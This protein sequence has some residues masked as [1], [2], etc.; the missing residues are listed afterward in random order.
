MGESHNKSGGVF[1]SWTRSDTNRDGDIGKLIEALKAL[2]VPYWIDDEQIGDF[3][4]I[5]EKVREG[6]SSSK[7]LL[8][9]YSCA[10]PTRKACREEITLALLAA[11]N[12]KEI[13]KR[14]LLLNPEENSN[15]ILEAPLL[16]SRFAN[17]DSLRNI[18]ELAEQIAERVSKLEHSF[19]ELPT[20]NLPRW[21]TGIKWNG[22][23]ERFVG[24]L[25]ELWKIHKY[26]HTDTEIAGTGRAGRSI[27]IVSGPGG[28]GKSLLASEYAHLFSHEYPGGVFW[29]SAFGND[30]SGKQVDKATED[31]AYSQNQIIAIGLNINPSGMDDELLRAQIA[32]RLER[33]GKDVLWIVDDLPSGLSS[34]QLA[35]W[36]CGASVVHEIIT[37]RDSSHSSLPTVQLDVLSLADA[38]SLLLKSHDRISESSARED[39][40]KVASILGCHPL[41]CDVAGLYMFRLN[42]TFTEYAELIENNLSKFDELAQAF[43][44]QLPGGHSREI[45]ATIGTSLKSL[46]KSAWAV[47]RLASQLAQAPIPR[48]LLK[49]TLHLSSSK[50]SFEEGIFGVQRDGLMDW[51]NSGLLVVHVLTAMAAL[52]LD[53]EPKLIP[54]AKNALISVLLSRFQECVSD[55]QRHGE[56]LYL[57]PHARYIT[58]EISDNNAAN[59]LNYVAKLDLERGQLT[60]AIDQ[61]EKLVEWDE[62]ILGPDHPD[63]LTSKNNLAVAYKK[64]GGLPKAIELLKETLADSERILGSDHPNTFSSKNNLAVAYKESGDLPKAIEL[65]KENLADRERILGSDH[66]KTL[67]SKNNLAMTY[68]ES[69][70]LQKAIE[71]LKET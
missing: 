10:Y 62:R 59:L 39:A 51:D 53:P 20:F 42:T 11:D 35:P 29:L 23:S 66:P 32:N 47:L 22:G 3:D 45:A 13:S 31:T 71:L 63:T 15:H 8:A 9:W 68:Q 7:V 48:T 14:V 28:I 67:S 37:T 61:F 40:E 5:S 34:E 43:Q 17:K 4:S 30:T 38:A 26:L 69:G 19:G 57:V 50:S 18:D 2:N 33:E 64:F 16:D 65:L 54:T 55:V 70:D 1:I 21:R 49:E 6:L 46:D 24:R 52:I 60:I 56:L 44:D 27:A 36:R 41:A 25:S 12:V 58:S